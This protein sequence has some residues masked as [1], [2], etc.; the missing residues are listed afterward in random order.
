VLE[1]N[2]VSEQKE[3][4]V[5][6]SRTTIHSERDQKALLNILE[7]QQ[8]PNDSLLQAAGEYKKRQKALDELSKLSEEMGLYDDEY[9]PLVKES[10]VANNEVLGTHTF[11]FNPSDNSGEQLCLTTEIFNNGDYARGLPNGMFTNQTLTL[12]SYCNHA[13]ISLYGN[14]ITPESLRQ[15]ADELEEAIQ[16]AKEKGTRVGKQ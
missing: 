10:S 9:N 5:K 14:P 7:N 12:Q 6:P 8:E 13:S 16:N 4:Q 15:L 2:Q 1:K 3:P 11:I